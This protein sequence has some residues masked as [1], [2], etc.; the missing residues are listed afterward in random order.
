MKLSDRARRRSAKCFREAAFQGRLGSFGRFSYQ[1]QQVAQAKA[2][3]AE[4]SGRF[5]TWVEK[6]LR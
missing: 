4:R 3:R 2:T 6:I 5:W 1:E